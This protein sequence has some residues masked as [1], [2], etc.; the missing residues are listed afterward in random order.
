MNKNKMKNFSEAIIAFAMFVFMGFFLPAQADELQ[1]N[2]IE[3]ALLE[4]I[5]VFRSDLA[6]NLKA[7]AEN[8]N[9]SPEALPVWALTLEGV[10]ASP[11]SWNRMVFSAAIS[12]SGEILV[13][14]TLGDEKPDEESVKVRLYNNG[15]KASVAREI[16]SLT[17]F[18]NFMSPASAV[19]ILFK[20]M[21]FKELKQADPDST[22]IFN[23]NL[24]DIGISVIPGTMFFGSSRYNV[25]CAAA[26]SAT[27]YGRTSEA[28]VADSLGIMMNQARVKPFLTGEIYG[29]DP[30]VMATLI[31]FEYFLN[32]AP[33]LVRA[34][35]KDVDDFLFLSMDPTSGNGITKIKKL[36]FFEPVDISQDKTSIAKSVF[37]KALKMEFETEPSSRIIFQS[38]YENMVTPVSISAEYKTNDLGLYGYE[39]TLISLPLKETNPNQI[40]GVLYR[41]SDK[42][43]LFEPG[44]G[45]ESAVMYI[46]NGES[47]VSGNSGLIDG[48]T[49]EKGVYLDVH[50]CDEVVRFENPEYS[51]RFVFLGAPDP[52]P[53]NGQ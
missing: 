41:D 1:Q 47:L 18:R 53:E 19:E 13:N 38:G 28:W 50:L 39:I 49:L 32:G 14:G 36:S 34:S 20:N 51:S 23:K 33:R 16:L 24:T 10:K 5:N 3:T 52:I 2:Y 21:I 29:Y 9:I 26:Y 7:F 43:G 30:G 6:G 17:A 46:Q 4:K 31:P 48:L 11:L 27:S 15:Y 35:Q 40:L 12:R 8:E 44:E 45:I 42:S 37:F 22:F 25:Y